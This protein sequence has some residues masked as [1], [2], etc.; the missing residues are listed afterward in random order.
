MA[1]HHHDDHGL[2]T[3][4]CDEVIDD[5]VRLAVNGPGGLRV[6]AAML[7]VEC[8]IHLIAIFRVTGR[9]VDDQFA[10]PTK[11]F[12]VTTEVA[13][14]VLHLCTDAAASIVGSNLIVDG[15]WSAQ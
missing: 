6:A 5:P 7:K 4:L 8:R 1:I 13:A 15:G 14:M 2:C 9:R 11:R 3:L 12:I 10:Q